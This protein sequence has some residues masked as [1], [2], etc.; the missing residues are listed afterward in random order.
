MTIICQF[1]FTECS[2]VK[3]R[4]RSFECPKCRE[5]WHSKPTKEDYER[6]VEIVR[7][8]IRESEAVNKNQMDGNTVLINR[9]LDLEAEL[10]KLGAR[11]GSSYD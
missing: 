6:I 3:G 1:C 4:K 10:I 9:I 5:I 2:P 8:K 11:L 7:G